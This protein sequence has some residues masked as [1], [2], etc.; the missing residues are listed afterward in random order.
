VKI[1]LDNCCY[2]RPSDNAAH[3]AQENVRQEITAILDT[4]KACQRVG[5]PIIGSPAV[6]DEIGKI[7]NAHKYERVWGFYNSAMSEYIEWTKDISNRA[8]GLITQGLK[9][10]DAHHTAFAEVAGADYLL[11]TDIRFERT[12]SRLKLAVIV[13]NPIIF[14]N[15]GY[16]L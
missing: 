11:T 6:V 4:V 3:L 10:T 7:S 15:G 8:N 16:A 13:M 12:A 2:C 9:K 14:I 1:Y 5:I